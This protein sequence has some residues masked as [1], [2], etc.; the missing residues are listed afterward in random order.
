M[1]KKFNSLNKEIQQNICKIF[2]LR[3]IM[4]NSNMC[5]LLK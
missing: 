4:Y 2:K 3:K 1:Q 5:A